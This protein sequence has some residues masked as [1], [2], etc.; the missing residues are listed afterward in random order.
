M[1]TVGG[2]DDDHL[3]ARRTRS[4]ECEPERGSATHRGERRSGRGP[5]ARC[6][7][8][9]SVR[10]R[11]SDSRTTGV[12]A[13][14]AG[15]E[16]SDPRRPPPERDGEL[17]RD[18][19]RCAPRR[20]RRAHPRR[21]RRVRSARGRERGSGSRGVWTQTPSPSARVSTRPRR[22]HDHRRC[23]GPGMR[24]LSSRTMPGPD[25]MEPLERL[26]NLVG[27]LL[28]T[29]TPLTFDQIR[30]TLDAYQGDNLDSIKRKFER[31]K[32]ML[33]AYGVPLEMTG[34]DAWDVE[35]GYIIRK[36]RYYLPD[37]AF[38]PEEITA[39]YLAAQ[40]G[41]ATA[42]AVTGRPQAAVRGR[43]RRPHRF[44]RGTARDGVRHGPGPA[45]G[46]RRRG[47]RSPRGAVRLPHGPGRHLRAHGRRVR[48]RLPDGALVPRG[49]RSGAR[50]G[51]GLPALPGDRAS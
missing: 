38:T 36:D 9:R 17:E 22:I 1:S 43:G 42:D 6:P 48:R 47:E 45:D 27:L 37:I 4:Q 13:S 26:L 15:S 40:S 23:R 7:R 50:R 19:P 25:T 20:P 16:G 44:R 33:R 12:D 34:T 3:G 18:A 14:P 35:Q 8:S 2:R 49:A 31:D 11:P 41:S 30:E 46:G 39:L 51:A 24:R 28:E 32:D 29:P 5:P 21:P 10:A